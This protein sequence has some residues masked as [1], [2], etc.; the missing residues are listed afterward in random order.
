MRQKSDRRFPQEAV[1]VQ[2][3]V[4]LEDHC[5]ICIRAWT[6]P[7]QAMNGRSLQDQTQTLDAQV[8]GC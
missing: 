1:L 4:T 2:E 7:L 8:G 5:S 3:L 6:K